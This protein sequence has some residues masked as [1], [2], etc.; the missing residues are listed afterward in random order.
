VRKLDRT[1][2]ILWVITMF[3]A[4]AIVVRLLTGLGAS[5]GLSDAMPW[6]VWKIINMVAGVALATGGFALA[7]IVYIFKIEK[8]RPY[9][10]P[11]I[12]IAFLGYGSSCFALFLDIGLPHRIWHP[13]VFWNHHSFLFEVAMCVMFYFTITILEMVPIILEKY[14]YSE[15][16]IQRIVTI[17]HAATVPLVIVGITLSSMHHTSL[18]SLFLVMPHRLHELWFSSWLPLN[19]FLSALG[20]GMMTVVFISLLYSHLYNKKASLSLLAGLAKGAAAV[21]AVYFMVRMADLAIHGHI[22]LVFSGE[23][24]SYF[25]LVEMFLAVLLPVVL[26]LQPRMRTSES[27]LAVIAGS[28]MLGLVLNRVNVG[29]TGILGTS[30][31]SY[32]PTL[33]EIA[34]M[35][36]V[37]SAAGLVFLFIV[38]QFD[39]FAEA[40]DRVM[41]SCRGP[42]PAIERL[43]QAWSNAYISPFVRI[44]LLIALSVPLAAGIFYADTLSGFPRQSGQ[45]KAPLALDAARSVLKINGNSDENYVVFKHVFHQQQ[46]GDKESCHECHHLNT[47]NDQSTPCY[48]CHQNMYLT[49]SIFDHTY[50]EQKLGD[51]KSCEQC[52]NLALN[53][54]L[55]NSKA[56]FACHEKDMMMPQPEKDRYNFQAPSYIDAMHQQCITCH[57]QKAVEL[58]KQNMA[59]C[60]H[61]HQNAGQEIFREQSPETDAESIVI[62]NSQRE[63]A[64]S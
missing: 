31:L 9:V 29:I 21:L 32:L 39:I 34:L 7:A 8:Y 41:I 52:H 20:A 47:P 17:F 2:E 46:L 45:V 12:L 50:H 56:C 35:A 61:C 44:S 63:G 37:L 40:P 28:A 43:T 33:P 42:E 54:S 13:I 24:E 58:D 11:A 23:W 1:K 14:Q 48:R 64:S 62:L 57:Q 49:H 18:G 15:R 53:K 25:F 30:E 4:V 19:F 55:N 27:G 59:T 5:T 3:G 36:G 16:T 10:K 26:I 38:E 51:N 22:R 60:Q 6:G